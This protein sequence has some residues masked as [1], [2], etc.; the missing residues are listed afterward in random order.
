MTSLPVLV[1]AEAE[2]DLA[3]ARDRYRAIDPV[4]E[5]GFRREVERCIAVISHM[6]ESHPLVFKS[7][8]RVGLRR[9]PSFIIYAVFDDTLVVFGCIHAR[10][11][12]TYWQSRA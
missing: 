10:R 4:L 7:L 11:D 2:V 9:F 3:D 6:P 1:T 12:P 5:S 8:R